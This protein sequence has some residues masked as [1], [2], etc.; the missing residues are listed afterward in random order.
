AR[1]FYE[2]FGFVQSVVAPNTLF[3]KV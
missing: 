3:Y 2:R 1:A